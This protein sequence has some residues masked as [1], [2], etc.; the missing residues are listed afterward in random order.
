L[1]SSKAAPRRIIDLTIPGA[2]SEEQER[3]LHEVMKSS[4]DEIFDQS[5][6]EEAATQLRINRA[7]NQ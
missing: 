1:N 7:A 5:L 6:A 3:I 2:W 4:P